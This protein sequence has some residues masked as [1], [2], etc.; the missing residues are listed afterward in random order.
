MSQP[1]SLYDEECAVCGEADG[2]DLML[3][4]GKLYKGRHCSRAY[5]IKCLSGIESRITQQWMCPYHFCD[6]C[7]NNMPATIMCM[8]CAESW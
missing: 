2:E 4:D 1:L 5:H 3:C 6:T 8:H 7:N